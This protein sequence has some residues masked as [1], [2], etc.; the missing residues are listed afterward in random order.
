MA[1]IVLLVRAKPINTIQRNIEKFA[2]CYRIEIIHMV[3]KTTTIFIFI[4]QLY[5]HDDCLMR[6]ELRDTVSSSNIYAE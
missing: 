2:H 6:T 3:P 4:T 1:E 5:Y